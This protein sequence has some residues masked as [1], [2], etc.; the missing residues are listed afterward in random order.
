MQFVALF[1]IDLE[2]SLNC[3]APGSIGSHVGNSLSAAEKNNYNLTGF[4]MM[5][6][7]AIYKD[8][9]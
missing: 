8:S 6:A 9:T 3:I 4:C 2:L 1:Y 5:L 7:Y